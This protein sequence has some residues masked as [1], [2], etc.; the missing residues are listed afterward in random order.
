[1][2]YVTT[3]EW[4]NDPH[5]TGRINAETTS[6]KALQM[7]SRAG[8]L[9]V[10]AS[11]LRLYY[12]ELRR[13]VAREIQF[14][15]YAVFPAISGVRQAYIGVLP[16]T[17]YFRLITD[18]EGELQ[19]SLFYENVRDYQGENL[20][21]QEI[22]FTLNHPD[23]RERLAVL[24]NGVTIVAKSVN[25]V[26]NT[27]RLQDFQIVNG[28]QT[29]HVLFRSRDHLG[30]NTFIPVKIIEAQDIE[31]V[32]QITKATNRQTE[33]KVEA[34]ES[35]RQFHKDLE[36]FY[37]HVDC[38]SDPRLYYER[39]SRQYHDTEVRRHQIVTMPFQLKCFIAAFLNEPHS[40][41][42]YY[43]ELLEAYRARVFNDVHSFWPYYISA[44]TR[45]RHKL[46]I[47][48]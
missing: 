27:F 22:L 37:A 46:R 17:E 21:N 33:V 29:S 6:L 43:G 16:C 20:V 42:R 3:G 2:Y 7:F 45:Y 38:G 28:C 36:E 24:N 26:G 5:L 15:R 1:M 39:R 18:S 9:P 48:M 44:Y 8:F 11:R 34:F 25:Q 41:H 23:W 14:E 35:L 30:D 4:T 31:L 47:F 32:N 19:R 12:Q 10:D 40:T 13:K